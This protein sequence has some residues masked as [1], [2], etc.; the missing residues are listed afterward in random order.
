MIIPALIR[1]LLEENSVTITEFGTFFVK[2]IPAQIKDD[3]IFPA[4]NIIEFEYSESAEGF[5]FVSKLSKWEQIG[6]DEAQTEIS[7]WIDL[8]K[9]G[10]EHNQT[11]FFDDF[12]TFSKNSLE[13]IVFQSVINFQLNIENE[14]FEP[15]I[16]P[17]KNQKEIPLPVVEPVQDKREI[18]VVRKKKKRDWI[19]FI[20][21]ILV[22]IALLGALF[23]K[24]T[25]SNFYKTIFVKSEVIIATEDEK[26]DTSAYISHI[27]EEKTEESEIIKNEEIHPQKTISEKDD[28]RL[29]Y[30]KGKFYVIAG[31]FLKEEDALRHIKNEKLEKYHPKLIVHPESPRIRVSIGV[32]DNEKDADAF[33]EKFKKNYWVLK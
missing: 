9:K 1:A 7:K 28:V 10:L 30:Q 26:I 11:L 31:S 32:F 22:A 16:L 3:I 2:K 24:D 18:F 20:I 15:V 13:K 21:I 23:F 12:G 33:A 29:T 14:G 4:Q 19:Y 6:M 8:L 27:M 25:L 5:D 17:S